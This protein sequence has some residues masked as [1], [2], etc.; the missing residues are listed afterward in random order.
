MRALPLRRLMLVLVIAGMLPVSVTSGIGLYALIQ[1]CRAQAERVGLEL[2]RAVITAV[3][4]ELRSS[5]AALEA[6]ATTST[7]DRADLVGFRG[8]ID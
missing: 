4:A 7:L 6:L 8:A 5:I 1:Q 2:A 3:D